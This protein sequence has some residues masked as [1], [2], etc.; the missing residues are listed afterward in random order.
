MK[1]EGGSI[2]EKKKRF[3]AALSALLA[4]SFMT[5]L[6]SAMDAGPDRLAIQAGGQNLVTGEPGPKGVFAVPQGNGAPV[7]TDGIFSPDEWSDARA[8]ALNE[9]V[10][11]LLKEFR[12][13]VFIGIRSRE[14]KL[15]GPSEIML[16]APGGPIVK[17]HVSAQLYETVLPP[18]G[19]E[20]APRLGLTED[21]Y[22]NEL[23]RDEQES[24]RLQKEGKSPYEII[25]AA[26]Y[27]CQGLE[28]AIRRTKLPGDAW[29]VRFWVTGFFGG[30]PGLLIW[31]PDAAERDTSGWLE[32]KLN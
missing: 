7:I 29:R 6:P 31:P 27:P 20:T 15:L 11:L 18:G 8:I 21:W 26:Y 12:G 19:G 16:S 2:M 5:A 28:F 24:A 13:V 3:P 14:N 1:R 4:A 25:Q 32:L 30:R 10:T 9:S 17:L 23:R 22:A